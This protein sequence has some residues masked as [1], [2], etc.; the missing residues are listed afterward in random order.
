MPT[1]RKRG[2]RFQAQVR[3]KDG[4]RIVHEQSATFDTQRQA[5]TWG[6]AIEEQFKSGKITQQK[7]ETTLSQ[8]VE[9]QKQSLLKADKELRGISHQFDALIASSLGAMQILKIDS[10]D[11]VEFARAHAKDRSPATVLHC[12]MVLR[13]CYQTARSEMGIKADIQEVADAT[14]HLAKL[15]LASKSTERDRRVTDDEIDRIC[16]HHESLLATTIP[17]RLLLN[18]A[19]ALPR[20]AGELFGG[21]QW[22]DYNGESVKLWDTKDPRK[23]RNEVVPVPP[24]AQAIIARLPKGPGAICPYNPQSVS[25]AVYRACKIVGIENLH[26][27]DLRH[28]GVS[29]LF[30]AGLDI[31]KVSMISGHQSWSTLRRYTHLKP[32]DVIDALTPTSKAKSKPRQRQRQEAGA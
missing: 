7:S 3:I 9:F 26:L 8:V 29:R 4:G 12:L 31:P 11:I 18:L 20:R 16:K 13:S 25:A 30:E 1:I 2:N 22:A 28:E 15:G 6:W 19:I 32:S 5:Q 10:S 21:M 27:H 23:V 17:L 24:K 14:K